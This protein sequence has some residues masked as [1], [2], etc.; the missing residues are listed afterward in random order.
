MTVFFRLKSVPEGVETT[1]PVW[2]VDCGFSLEE[3]ARSY[4]DG[5]ASVGCLRG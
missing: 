3:C 1:L 2:I 4:W 5:P